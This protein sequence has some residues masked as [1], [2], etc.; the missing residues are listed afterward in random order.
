ML[1]HPAN[2]GPFR[3]ELFEGGAQIAGLTGA[4]MVTE[5]EAAAAHYAASRR[6]SDGEIIAVYDLGGG[7]FDATVLR[8]TR[9]ASRSSVR[10]RASSASGRRLRRGDPD[11]RQ[12]YC[13]GGA[14]S[15]LDMSDPQTA[16][17]MAR[18][19]QDCVLAKESLSV[20]TETAIPVF[21]P[22]RHFDVTLN[23]SDFEDMI[24]APIESTIGTLVRTLRSANVG[25]NQLSAVLL[26]GGSSRIPLVARMISRELGR[27]TVVDAHPKY[28]VA[29]GAATLARAARRA[30]DGQA[31]T[32]RTEPERPP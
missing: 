8:K 6:L 28:A 21:L 23:R 10:R 32:L 19:R 3:R 26:V 1:T 29:L 9:T 5:P 12:R 22:N 14:L 30:V 31:P 13:S 24:R 16:V 17:A 11:L 27:P 15:E 2:W 20:D 18:L 4:W 7:T 25:L